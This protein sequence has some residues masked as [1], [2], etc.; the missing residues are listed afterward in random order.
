MGS[1]SDRTRL[2]DRPLKLLGR[3]GLRG[4][5]EDGGKKES[6]QGSERSENDCTIFGWRKS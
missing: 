6:G 5:G 2:L 4:E 1:D 3:A